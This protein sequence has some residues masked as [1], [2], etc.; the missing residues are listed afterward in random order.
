[1]YQ[2][3]SLEKTAYVQIS[4]ASQTYT[5]SF[6]WT[7]NEGHTLEVRLVNNAS[8]PMICMAGLVLD[9]L[10][11]HVIMQFLSC[12]YIYMCLFGVMIRILFGESCTVDS[13]YRIIR[14]SH[15]YVY[16]CMGSK[17]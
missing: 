12:V 13:I 10:A 3:P 7:A 6:N 4:H 15:V 1:M 16:T 8:E 5:S 17:L 14:I 9:R 2:L 11:H